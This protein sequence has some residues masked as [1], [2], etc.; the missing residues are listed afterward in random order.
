MRKIVFGSLVR[1]K[2][3][4]AAAVAVAA[5]L[6][7]AVWAAF[8][9]PGEKSR[10]AADQSRRQRAFAVSVLAVPARQSDFPIYITGLGTVTPLQSVTVR[11]RV[12]GELLEVLYKEGQV[13]KSGQLIARID[14][15]PFQVQ[16][17]QAEGQQARDQELLRN[18]R[19]DLERY[20]V[21]WQQDSIPKQQLDTQQALVRQYEGNVKTDQGLI[22]SAKLQI[23]YSRITAPI[24]GRVGL[25]LVDPGNIV[26]ASDAT[27]LVVITQVEPIAVIFP[28]PE[29]NL[30]PVLARLRAGERPPV[31]AFDREMKQK[32][33]S[34][35]LLTIDNQI[36]PTTGT[37]RLKAVFANKKSELF[38]NQFVNVRLLMNVRKQATVVPASA[39]Q[40]GPKGTFVYVVKADSTAEMRLVALGEI[41]GGD[42]SIRTGLKPG[43]MV[44]IDGSDRIREGA[45]VEVKAPRSGSAQGDAAGK[46][47]AAPKAAT[48]K[49][50]AAA[51][52][53]AGKP[54]QAARP[55]RPGRQ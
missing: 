19:L 32:L 35:S 14:P 1:R 28:I 11:S 54:E 36:D 40:R 48:G 55:D 2:A 45:K 39:L 43:E 15:R 26:R 46:P 50:D 10:Q 38:P 22:D 20:K 44:V 23:T 6:I 13:V 16:L 9:Y 30:P 8:F 34:G 49:P 5:V 47:E 7:A 37:V 17:L 18:A 25:R 21:L 51:Q 33:A 42:A 4:W 41:Q 31:E 24:G 53:V 12:D 29:D 3:F 27:G 52:P